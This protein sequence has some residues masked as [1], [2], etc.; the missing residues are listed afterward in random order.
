MARE[1]VD[2]R[3]E[4]RPFQEQVPAVGLCVGRK[5]GRARFTYEERGTYMPNEA[6]EGGT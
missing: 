3:Q 2:H 1:D 4:L 5:R 6:L